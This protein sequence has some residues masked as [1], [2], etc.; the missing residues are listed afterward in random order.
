[1]FCEPTVAI[2]VGIICL[3][4]LWLSKDKNKEK[5]NDQEEKD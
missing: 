3:I 2:I 1:M 5:N 4:L